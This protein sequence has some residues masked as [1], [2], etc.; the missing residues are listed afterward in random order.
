MTL[1]QAILK[2]TAGAEIL[3]EK[4]TVPFT[5]SAERA[6]LIEQAAAIGI[7]ADIAR[8]HLMPAPA[9]D[10]AEA[11]ASATLGRRTS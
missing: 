9:A 1:A 2:A 6:L 10:I 7:L 5:P 11:L 8:Q 4:A 3:R